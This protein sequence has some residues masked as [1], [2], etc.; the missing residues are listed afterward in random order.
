M[1]AVPHVESKKVKAKAW[2]VVLTTNEDST[3]PFCISKPKSDPRKIPMY[4]VSVLLE[5]QD[6]AWVRGWTKAK[7]PCL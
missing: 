7:L 6:I 4:I 2:E 1:L 5:N 3:T